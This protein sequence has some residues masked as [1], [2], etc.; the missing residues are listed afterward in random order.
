MSRRHRK[1]KQKL[2]P[3]IR[4]CGWL[5]LLESVQFFVL[6]VYHFHLN[7]GAYLFSTLFSRW[8]SG[9]VA[10]TATS[11]RIFVQQLVDNAASAQLLV[12]L[13]ESAVLFLLTVFTLWAAVG[14]FRAWPIA[15]TAGVFVQAG[16]LLTSLILYFVN[17][18]RHIIIMMVTGI[19]MVL[20][21][22]YADV[23][24]FF[25]ARQNNARERLTE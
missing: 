6:G 21:L 7:N 15:W 5:L 25:H 10:P 18:P 1:P 17:K 14:F 2:P 13:N 23:Q 12:A 16:A 24:T 11:I 3:L 22:N 19:F 4:Q 20:Y 8:L 9:E